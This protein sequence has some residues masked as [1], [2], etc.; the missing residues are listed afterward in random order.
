VLPTLAAPAD[1]TV[2]VELATDLHELLQ[3]AWLLVTAWSQSVLDATIA[4]VPSITVNPT[5]GPDPVTF[6]DEGLAT[7]THDPESAAMAAKRLLEPAARQ[8][9]IDGARAALRLRLGEVD[10]RAAERTAELIARVLRG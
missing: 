7:G 2:R 9:A 8:S 5:G 3:G 6:A 4:G 1:V 10:G